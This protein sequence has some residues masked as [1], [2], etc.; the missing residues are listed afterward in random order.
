MNLWSHWKTCHLTIT[1]WTWR[2]SLENHSFLRVKETKEDS[3]EREALACVCLQGCVPAYT[4]WVLFC[5]VFFFSFLFLWADI[6]LYIGTFS[7]F[8]LVTVH[9]WLATG[10]IIIF[11]CAFFTGQWLF[12]QTLVLAF[13]PYLS[14][15]TQGRAG[16]SETQRGCPCHG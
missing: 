6:N 9:C 13:F 2:F 11:H 3:E 7:R 14:G 5:F 15:E 10:R 12:C 16:H 4:G 1:V 8:Q